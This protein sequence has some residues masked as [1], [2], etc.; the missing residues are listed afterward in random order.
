MKVGT[1]DVFC[2][3]EPWNAQ[4]V[5]QKI[6]YT[7]VTTGEIWAKHPEKSLGMR[8]D[9]VEQNPNAAKALLMAVHGGA[10]SGATTWRTRTEMCAIVGRRAWFNVPVADIL[11]RAAR[12]TTTTATA[13]RSSRTARTS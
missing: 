4:L 2:V 8:A 13:A 12:A 10:A 6:G 9:W 5:N 3:G 7:A 1:M 11:G